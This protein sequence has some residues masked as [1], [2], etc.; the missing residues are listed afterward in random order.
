MLKFFI[1]P[2]FRLDLVTAVNVFRTGKRRRQE[3]ARKDSTIQELH[4]IF[5]SRSIRFEGDSVGGGF[6]QKE[7]GQQIQGS[8]GSVPEISR[9][10]KHGKDLSNSFLYGGE[11]GCTWEP[12]QGGCGTNW[13]LQ[14]LTC[15]ER[16]F[17]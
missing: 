17:A 10:G 7:R 2:D 12:V 1:H 11:L 9:S 13:P 3:N 8:A 4:P 15:S 14:H 5:R 16:S 6:S